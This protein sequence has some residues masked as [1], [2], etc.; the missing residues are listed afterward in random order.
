MQEKTRFLGR[1][2]TVHKMV[3]EPLSRVEAVILQEAN[4]SP[5][6]R[7]FLKNIYSVGGY[8]WRPIKGQRSLSYH[9]FG[10]A[11]DILPKNFEQL[12][13]YWQ[14]VME[15]QDDWAVLP[16]DQRWSPP[17]EVIQAFEDNGF[18]WGG[19]WTMYD[20]MHFEYRPEMILMRE[21]YLPA[22]LYR[23]K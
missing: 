3:V 15:N 9:S 8:N 1:Q 22:Y 14:W 17:S 18:I 19:K 7:K 2:I 11:V 5:E 20:N 23:K 21:R 13:L 4:Y 6:V 10:I 12:N 16:L